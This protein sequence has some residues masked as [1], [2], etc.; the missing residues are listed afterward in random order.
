MAIVQAVI[1]FHPSNRQ[2]K[3]LLTTVCMSPFKI[4]SLPSA[5]PWE[6]WVRDKT[7]PTT[8]AYSGS[9]NLNTLQ[10]R[11]HMLVGIRKEFKI[12][13]V[14]WVRS[15]LFPVRKTVAR[16]HLRQISKKDEGRRKLS[17]MLGSSPFKKPHRLGRLKRLAKRTYPSTTKWVLNLSKLKPCVKFLKSVNKIIELNKIHVY[18][19]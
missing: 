14:I 9:C 4:G 17:K 19:V 11:T 18:Y 1:D 5:W 10:R 8:Y 2:S 3:Q 6:I 16:A 13:K 15:A 7:R 12:S